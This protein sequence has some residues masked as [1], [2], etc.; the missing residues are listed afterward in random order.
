[1]FGEEKKSDR[2]LSHVG[3]GPS[4]VSPVTNLGAGPGMLVGPDPSHEHDQT[5][6]V[7]SG[8]STLV[9]RGRMAV[10]GEPDSI[11]EFGQVG[12]DPV[13]GHVD[14]SV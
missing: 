9:A 12:S 2:T 1:M 14:L 10:Y 6:L 3:P 8:C 13:R 11:C 5:L 4:W 7:R